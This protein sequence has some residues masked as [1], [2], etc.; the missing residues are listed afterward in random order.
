MEERSWDPSS[1]GCADVAKTGPLLYDPGMALNL[2]AVGHK[3]PELLHTYKWQDVALYAL[4]LG[5]TLDELEFLYEKHGPKVLPTY[6][7]VPTFPVCG[8]LFEAVG[9]DLKG[10]VHGAQRIKLHKNFKPEGTLKTV[11]EVTAVYDLKRMAETIFSTQTF[12][13]EGDLVCETEWS[14]LYRF[15]G[16]FDGPRP[17]KRERVKA[18]AVDPDFEFVQPTA[19]E[20][21]ALYRLSGDLN[22]LHIDPELATEVGFDRPILHGLCTYG[23]VGRALVQRAAAG[24]PSRVKELYGQFRRPVWPGDTIVVK[25]WN[26]EERLIVNASTKERPEENAFANAYAKIETP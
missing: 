8:K 2:S 5:A 10:V 12:D 24:E 26:E 6:A 15:D 3:T 17:P 9:G 22:P 14:I 18:P 25:G 11:G 21:A 16:G 13:E 23:I 20:Q 1:R 4:G 19:P 7:V